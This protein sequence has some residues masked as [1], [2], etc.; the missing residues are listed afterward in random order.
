MRLDTIPSPVENFEKHHSSQENTLALVW[1][2]AYCSKCCTSSGLHGSSFENDIYSVI[3]KVKFTHIHWMSTTDLGYQR[4]SDTRRQKYQEAPSSSLFQ[5]WWFVIIDPPSCSLNCIVIQ[6][7]LTVGAAKI[8]P[9]RRREAIDIQWTPQVPI[10]L[11]AVQTILFHQVI[12]TSKV[13][14][15]RWCG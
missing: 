12:L 1:N 11:H 3:K 5:Q 8:A 14:I 15:S 13:R 7:Y 4:A 2:G 10:L 9:W 6:C